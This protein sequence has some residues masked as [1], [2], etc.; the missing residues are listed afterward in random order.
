MVMF[1][2]AYEILPSAMGMKLPFPKLVRLHFWISI[3]G[4][5][6]FVVPLF[7]A[8]V[9]QGRQW[10]DASVAFADANQ[11]ALK[12][13]RIS[14]VGQLLFFFGALLFALNLFVLAIRWEL[15]R[16]KSLIAAIKAPLP[17]AEAKP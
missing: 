5:A 4:V 12:Y 6:L 3:L 2:A 17:D 10:S 9:E 8:G 1:G 7:I 13:L 11:V 14:T 16:F 15:A